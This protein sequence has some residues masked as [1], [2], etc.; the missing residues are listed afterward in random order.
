MFLHNWDKHIVKKMIR[1]EK[2]GEY[3]EIVNSKYFETQ[4][5][6][7]SFIYMYYFSTNNTMCMQLKCAIT[8][9]A[10]HIYNYLLSF[11]SWGLPIELHM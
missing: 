9:D 5:G 7:V 10:Y 4:Y 3:D 1:R 11:L 8:K 6:Q 2:L